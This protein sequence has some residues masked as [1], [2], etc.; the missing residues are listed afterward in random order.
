MT[1]RPMAL[2][3]T[4]AAPVCAFAAARCSRRSSVPSPGLAR[5]VRASIDDAPALH[6][7]T[8][9]VRGDGIQEA[10]VE[11]SQ[12]NKKASTWSLLAAGLALVAAVV[13]VL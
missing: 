2:V 3:L 4:L 8:A 12:R 10:F 11:A 1:F 7:L 6:L 5:E 13:G 9:Q